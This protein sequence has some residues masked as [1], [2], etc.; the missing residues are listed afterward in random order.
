MRNEQE[1]FELI[2]S[3]AKNDEWIRVVYMN[4][5]RTIPEVPKD[6]FKDYDIVYV[7]TETSSFIRDENWIEISY[8]S[9]EWRVSTELVT[10]I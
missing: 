1:M 6:I 8:C 2:I 5:S 10:S 9:K 4:G 7:V 3:V